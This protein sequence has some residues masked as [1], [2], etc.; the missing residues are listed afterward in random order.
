[1]NELTHTPIP[2][3]PGVLFG[4]ACT[5][6]YTLGGAPC[7]FRS[8]TQVT[9]QELWQLRCLPR[10]YITPHNH[11]PE[12][13]HCLCQHLSRVCHDLCPCVLVPASVCLCVSPC[14]SVLLPVCFLGGLSV[15][16]GVSVPV[17]ICPLVELSVGPSVRPCMYQPCG[18]SVRLSVSL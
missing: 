13:S 1:M 14:R 8:H 6:L 7:S 18:L 2:L 16:V 10:G 11:K 5:P 4:A 9:Q 17:S 15:P 12:P 3:R